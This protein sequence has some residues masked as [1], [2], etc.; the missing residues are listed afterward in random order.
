MPGRRICP[1]PRP[2]ASPIRHCDEWG[3]VSPPVAANTRSRLSGRETIAV[4][5]ILPLRGATV[6]TSVAA[7]AALLLLGVNPVTPQ[8]TAA[9]P[10]QVVLV[11]GGQLRCLL[12]AN[13][14]NRG[15][16]AAVC[17]RT[18]GRGFGSSP[19][20]TGKN[21]VRLNLVVLRGTGEMWWEAGTIPGAPADDVV[22]SP[23]Q[24][25]AV[26]G[27][28]VTTSD[29]RTVVKDDATGHG[30]ILNLADARQF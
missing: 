11:H 12:S 19:M 17:G 13:Y 30:V 15:R 5:A 8:A 22:V 27:W 25:Y 20:S 16:A 21:P 26:N 1:P 9:D 24:P 28:T 18:D 10:D 23:G 4:V 2:L 3:D 14:Q 6:R 29:I 7:A